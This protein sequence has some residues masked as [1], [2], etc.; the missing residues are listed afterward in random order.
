MPAVLRMNIHKNAG[1][2][3]SLF[4]IPALVWRHSQVHLMFSLALRCAPKG[5]TI[6][7]IVL[8]Y[9]SPAIPVTPVPVV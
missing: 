1:I 8:Q 6:P 3:Q 2:S 9:Q 4:V 5:I 7:P